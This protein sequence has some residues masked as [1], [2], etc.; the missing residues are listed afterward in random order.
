MRLF[1]IDSREEVTYAS[2]EEYAEVNGLGEIWWAGSGDFGNAYTT[3]IGT[4]L[5]VTRDQSEIRFAK[6]IQGK[7]F[8]NVV[9]IF[10]VSGYIIHM[11]ELEV[12]DSMIESLFYEAM[13]MVESDD[14]VDYIYDI[15]ERDH[16][17]MSSELVKFVSELHAGM[18]ELQY[19]G[20]NNYDLHAGNIGRKSSGDYAIFDMSASKRGFW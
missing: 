3:G 5:K 4:I 8:K 6:M 7:K 12:G 17:E 2:V 13:E 11:E 14:T 19:A 15:D 20:I 16:P 10:D 9:N 1:E 18:L